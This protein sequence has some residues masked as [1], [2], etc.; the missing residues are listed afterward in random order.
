MSEGK[1]LK[2]RRA[3][4]SVFDKSGLNDIVDCLVRHKVEM[5]SS[6]G[7]A[8]A[9]R[10]RGRQCIDVSEYTGYPESPD[11]L[12]KTLQPKIHG[13]LLLDEENPAHKAYMEKQDRKSVV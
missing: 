7:T 3:L 8:K 12:V 2:V 11:G 13:G 4:V 5:I 9:I 6:G 10:A 1:E